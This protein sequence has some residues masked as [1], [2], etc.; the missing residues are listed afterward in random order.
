MEQICRDGDPPAEH[1]PHNLVG[2]WAQYR[3]C[4][5]EPDWLLIYAVEE[6]VVRFYRSGAHLDL[7]N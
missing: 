2:N 3:E 5:I 1:S 7:F 4:H 6:D